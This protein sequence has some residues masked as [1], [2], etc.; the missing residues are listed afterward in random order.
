MRVLFVCSGNVFRSQI[1]EAFFSKYS[2]KNSAT[3]AGIEAK[4]LHHEGKKLEGE[5]P[6]AVRLMAEVGID[7]SKN[8]SKQ[9]TKATA[10]AADL[11][12][13][14][15]NTDD[16]PGYLRGDKRLRVWQVSNLNPPDFSKLD[17]PITTWTEDNVGKA[18]YR[19]FRERR[20]Q[21]ETNVVRLIEE[22]G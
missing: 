18:N 5:C 1:A 10:R 22:I 17:R 8:R 21:I 19:F 12:I 20:D 14:L 7:V 15:I 3:S 11:I 4:R 16:L 9:M 2:K 6:L 13:W